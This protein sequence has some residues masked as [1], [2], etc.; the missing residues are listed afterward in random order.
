MIWAA[1][2]LGITI[3]KVVFGN[4]LD[5]G[6]ALNNYLFL[7]LFL[8]WDFIFYFLF[9][10]LFYFQGLDFRE[11]SFSLKGTIIFVDHA[12]KLQSTDMKASPHLIWV[13]LNGC[14]KQLYHIPTLLLVF[15]RTSY[16]VTLR[17]HYLIRLNIFSIFLHSTSYVTP[18]E[19]Y[20]RNE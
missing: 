17:W 13:C 11:T 15:F 7:F 6:Q 9:P 16:I 5:L 19:M 12:N 1:V 2:W 8:F 10:P 4:F 14:I 3:Y 18:K 20:R